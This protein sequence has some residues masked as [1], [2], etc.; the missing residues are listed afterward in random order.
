VLGFGRA[1]GETMALAML[2]GIP[3]DQSVAVRPA[4]TLAALAGVSFPEAGPVEVRALSMPPGAAGHHLDRQCIG[5][6]VMKFATR[7]LRRTMIEP[8]LTATAD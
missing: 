1:L 5:L 3:P 8:N 7:N 6:A 2:I 4:N